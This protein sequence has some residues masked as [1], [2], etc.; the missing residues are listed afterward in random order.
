MVAKPPEHVARLIRQALAYIP[1]EQMVITTVQQHLA[2]ILDQT[3]RER[4][5]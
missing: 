2:E 5:V 1:P 3:C 4:A